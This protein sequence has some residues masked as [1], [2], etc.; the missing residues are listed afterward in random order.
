[1][2]VHDWQIS[3]YL[4]GYSYCRGDYLEIVYKCSECEQFMTEKKHYLSHEKKALKDAIE[5]LD[6]MGFEQV[7][8]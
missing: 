2:K 4:T 3:H 8:F 7:P 5:H 1:M 6:E